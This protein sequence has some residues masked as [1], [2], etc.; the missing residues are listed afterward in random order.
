V[1][2][3]KEKDL[4]MWLQQNHYSDLVMAKSPIS[5]WDCYSPMSYHRI[6]LKCRKKH[7][8]EGL[9]I[10]KI[11][12]EAILRKCDDNLDIPIYIN[13]TPSGIYRFNLYKVKTD[14]HLKRLPRTT[15]F[16]KRD[17]IDKEVAMLDVIDAE[18]L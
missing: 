10:E 5:R 6:E 8:P 11:K 9:M 1:I 17:W 15:E 3:W 16:D 18:I 7:Y 14:W 13:S 2:R 4:F 12:Y